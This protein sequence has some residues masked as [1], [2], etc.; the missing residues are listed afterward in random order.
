MATMSSAA[1]EMISKE[2][3][4]P[5]TP[6]PYQLR[7]F[8]IS[9]FDQYMPPNYTTVIL[10]YPASIAADS[11]GSELHD[12]LGLLK[13]SLSETLVH[14]YPMAGR[15]KDNMVVECNDQGVDFY[16]V[17]IKAKMCDF[18]VKPDE[19]PLNLLLPYEVVSKNFVKE[20]QVIVQVNMF[21]CGGTAISLCVS[22]KI[23]DACTMSTFIR[24][25]AGNTYSARCGGAPTTNQ[26]SFPS[27]DSASLFPPSEQLVFPSEVPPTLVSHPTDDSRREKSV[28]KRFVFDAVK[29]NSV[30]EKLPV[31][32]HDNY[33]SSS[34]PTRV[35]VVT[36]LVWKAAMKSAPSDDVLPTVNHV[37][38]FR[39]KI[40]PPLPDV[41]FGNL[42]AVV[43][44]AVS[45]GATVTSRNDGVEV[46]EVL[47]DQLA[48]LV[49]QLRG[50]KYKVKGDKGCIEKIFLSFVG[51]DNALW[52]A[53]WSKFGFYDADFGWG[54]PVWV[55]TDL[56]I[57][58]PNQNLICMMDTKCGEGIEVSAK[59]LENDMAKFELHLSKILELF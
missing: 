9:L 3:I 48:E 22:H 36:A 37:V 56:S 38:S 45:P 27:F 53:S 8:N 18:M 44:T 5:T 30:R 47:E 43:A 46:Q 42:C 33:K 34:R 26:N 24:N 11:T 13:R 19:F 6:T 7:N 28:S 35:D 16:E 55:T 32:M 14:F 52:M 31:L 25:W 17:K 39:K 49:A 51:G 12:D 1:V 2:I 41:S 21:D 15:L 4:K 23:A 20:A 59:F 58:E 29:I 54:R 57:V 10:F 40:D 50:E